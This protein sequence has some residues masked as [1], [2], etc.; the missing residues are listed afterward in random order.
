MEMLWKYR[1]VVLVVLAGHIA[2]HSMVLWKVA[3]WP[4]KE[5]S[6]QALNLCMSRAE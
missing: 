3:G 6:T 4:L 5:S 1:D 2:L